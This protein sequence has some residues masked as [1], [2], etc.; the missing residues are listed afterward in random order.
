MSWVEA[1]LREQPEALERFLEAE[2]GNAVALAR[3]L[4]QADVRY[5]LIA[6]RGS[7]GNAARYARRSS[8]RSPTR[9]DSIHTGTSS[10]AAWSLAE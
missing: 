9:S 1:E 10:R 7:S 3:E 2:Q 6:S 4:V 5:L 8:A